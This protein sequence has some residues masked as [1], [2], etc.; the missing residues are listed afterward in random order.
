MAD[1]PIFRPSFGNR[2]DQIVG[3]ESVLQ[4]YTE[5]LSSYPG[6]RERALLLLGQR[7]MGKTALL[8][9]MAD[10]ALD[11][12]FVPVRTTCG[13]MMLDNILDSLQRTG[14]QYLDDK[15]S[16]VK[17]FSAGALGFSFGLTFT[18]KVRSSYGFRT[19]LEMLCDR[20]ADAHKG[21]A[22]L[23]DEVRP[24]LSSMR[25]LATAYQELVGDGKNVAMVMAG[26]PSVVSE[27]LDEDTLTFLNRAN[28]VRLGPISLGAVRAYYA[29]AFARAKRRIE[30]AVLEDATR[31]TA[32]FPYLLQLIG[33]YL[34]AYTPEGG[35]IT[36]D[37]LLNAKRSA[38]ADLDENV[39]RAMIRP[40]SRADVEFLEAMSQD[41]GPTRTGSLMERLGVSQGHVQSYRRRLLDAGVITAPRRGEVA[42]VIPQLADYLRR[43]GD[44]SL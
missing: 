31:A 18:E 29:S 23:V 17:G 37:S 4:A 20:L 38:Y 39:F 34:L 36:P 42:F 3:R 19:K 14:A 2:P 8:L 11:A 13:D 35:T 28:K 33:Y 24:G 22:L 32:G 26:L 41:I 25:Q 21:V 9:H 40:L 27:V 7:G 16:P 44:E 1:L 10:I 43:A 6:S 5:G 30:P 15:Q 12:G